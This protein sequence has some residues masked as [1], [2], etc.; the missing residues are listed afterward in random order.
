MVEN[1]F[2]QFYTTSKN[3]LA[4]FANDTRVEEYD[5]SGAGIMRVPENLPSFGNLTALSMKENFLTRFELIF[6]FVE[7][8]PIEIKKLERG[9]I[10]LFFFF[11]L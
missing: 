7:Y 10:Y 11:R 8:G 4:K 6:I 3:A 5:L 9:L 1:P 2:T